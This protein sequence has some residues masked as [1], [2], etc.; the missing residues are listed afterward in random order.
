M[1]VDWGDYTVRT[2]VGSGPTKL[3]DAATAKARH[4]DTMAQKPYRIE[5]LRALL[6]RNGLKF[7]DSDEAIQALH[8][9]VA[10]NVELG[11]VNPR[12]PSAK[13][14]SVA[15]D[16]GLFLGEVRIS[17]DPHH[18]R[19]AYNGNVR[20]DDVDFQETVVESDTG[21]ASDLQGAVV[22]NM[23]RLA[24]KDELKYPLTPRDHH[25]FVEFVNPK[26][27]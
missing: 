19:W 21:I 11:D 15:V 7:G 4:E 20:N 17:K 6:A 18:R 14:L 16:I 22:I 13:W 23:T 5:Q 27:G 12:M 1:A 26:F 2:S 25:R 9:W 24:R 3:L 10:A 8:D